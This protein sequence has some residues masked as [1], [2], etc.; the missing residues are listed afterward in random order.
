MAKI[1]KWTDSQLF[2]AVA[3]S[4]TYSEVLRQIGL[5]LCGGSH[6]LIKQRIKQLGLDTSHFVGRGW[7]NGE[8]YKEF[9]KK[10]IEYPIERVFVKDSTYTCT[11]SLKKKIYKYNLIENRCYICDAEP[12]WNNSPLVMQLDHL[13]GD[14]CNN[15]LKNLR[16]LCPNCHSQT[17]TFCGRNKQRASDNTKVPKPRKSKTCEN[18]GKGVSHRATRCEPCA[19]KIRPKKIEWMPTSELIKLVN[20]T[21]YLAASRQLGVSDNAIRKRIKKSQLSSYVRQNKK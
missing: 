17:S 4:T 13:D 2:K 18:C 21:S 11:S 9:S 5:K 7:C 15:E 20:E 10:H 16:L 1:R 6:A 14:R 19:V 8:L 12:M 3:D